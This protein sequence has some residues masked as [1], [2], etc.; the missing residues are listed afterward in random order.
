[1]YD[2]SFD[3]FLIVMGLFLAIIFLGVGVG[4]CIGKD[5]SKPNKRNSENNR[6]NI[7]NGHGNNYIHTDRTD[8]SNNSTMGNFH[9]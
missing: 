8:N 1:M 9:E 5:W 4:V 7:W 3:I 6:K 2:F